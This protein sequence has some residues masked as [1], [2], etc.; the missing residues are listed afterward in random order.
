MDDEI[1]LFLIKAFVNKIKAKGLL[2][3]LEEEIKRVKKHPAMKAEGR[4]TSR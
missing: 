1:S 4:F 3:S 2:K